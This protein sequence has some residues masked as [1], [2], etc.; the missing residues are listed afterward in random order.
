M[1]YPIFEKLRQLDKEGLYPFHMP[2]HKRKK[3]DIMREGSLFALDTTEISG[4][5]DLHH[6]EGMIKESME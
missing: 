4:Y 1:K 5:D 2:G 6:P 3:Q